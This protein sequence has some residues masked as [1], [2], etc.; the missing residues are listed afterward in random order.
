MGAG[1]QP[2]PCPWR[3]PSGDAPQHRGQPPCSAKRYGNAPALAAAPRVDQALHDRV[4]LALVRHDGPADQ[5]HQGTEEGEERE[6]GHHE[7]HP[8]GGRRDAEV[9][10]EARAHAG[11]QASLALAVERLAARVV[12]M[13]MMP[14]RRP[15]G[16]AQPWATYA[17]G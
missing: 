13:S 4:L 10:G 6:R 8:D 14:D 2:P 17:S 15:D 16:R 5:V 7:D 11:Y 9:V 12:H 1:R 3:P